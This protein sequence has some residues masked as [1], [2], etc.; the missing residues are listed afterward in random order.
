MLSVRR[1]E[2]DG[3]FS[4]KERDAGLNPAGAFGFRSLAI[5]A[6]TYRFRLFPAFMGCV[7]VKVR[8]TSLKKDSLHRLFPTLPSF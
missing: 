6:L 7:V 5:R 1:G 4:F 2:E 8:D 3:Y